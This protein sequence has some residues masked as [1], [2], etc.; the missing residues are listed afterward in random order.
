MPIW[1]MVR[2]PQ[3][4]CGSFPECR[5]V[6][7][8][9]AIMTRV[10]SASNKIPMI[11]ASARKTESIPIAASVSVGIIPIV[12]DNQ[13]RQETVMQSFQSIQ[14]VL[15]YAIGQEQQAYEFYLGLAKN[16]RDIGL[17][18]AL[19][20]FALEELGHKAKLESI[21]KGGA[22]LPSAEKIRTLG[23]AEIVFDI[24]PSAQMEY[25]DTLL[26]AMKKEKQA[27]TLYTR[28]GDNCTDAAMRKLFHGLAQEE[29]RH[30][31]RFELEYDQFVLKED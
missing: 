16:A 20:E 8:D 17:A 27:Y 18:R 24:Q 1:I 12:Y 21:K 26:L 30:K 3:N 11:A 9:N 4:G 22:A 29:A 5:R 23:L 31:L 14:E 6:N 10:D 28:L 13:N 25:K 15:D 19:E 2:S 7:T